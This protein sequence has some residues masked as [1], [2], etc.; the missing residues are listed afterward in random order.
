MDH[1]EFLLAFYYTLCFG[2][3][4]LGMSLENEKLLKKT[5]DH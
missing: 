1:L 2:K 4:G 3:E 5:G